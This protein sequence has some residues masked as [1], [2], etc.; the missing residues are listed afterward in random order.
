MSIYLGYLGHK[1][2]NV[3][4]VKG[5]EPPK[6]L[7]EI[8]ATKVV[9]LTIDAER[10]G[11]IR[12]ARVRSMGAKNRQYAELDGD[13]RGAG[14]GDGVHRRLGCPVIDVTE[15]SV[16]ET[17]MRIVRIVE[18]R[19]A[20]AAARSRVRRDLSE[21]G[22]VPLRYWALWWS[23]LAAAVVVFD[24]SL[25]PFWL[26]LRAAAWAAELRSRARNRIGT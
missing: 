10:L 6:E 8:D 19:K 17:A 14:R 26:G 5:I 23:I 18:R 24:V 22:S 12:S 3:P 4:I 1:T 25:T 7:F 20:D 15:L 16:E 9:G 11:E 21:K 2:A 13:L